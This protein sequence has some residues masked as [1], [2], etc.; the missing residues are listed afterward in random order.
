M[1]VDETGGDVET[2]GVDRLVGGGFGEISNRGDPVAGDGDV[3]INPG[4]SGTV[5]K[6][7]AADEKIVIGGIR[8][9][10][11]D[12]ENSGEEERGRWISHERRM[13]RRWVRLRARRV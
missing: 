9:S 13:E 4:I 12:E 10:A 11:R 6:A 3:G 7:S 2:G 1:G 8:A 5:E